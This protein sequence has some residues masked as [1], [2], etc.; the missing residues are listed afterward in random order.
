MARTALLNVMVGAALK[1]GR[2]LARDFGEVENLQVSVKG[3][4]DFV[5]AADRKSEKIIIDELRKARPTFGFLTEETGEIRGD[6]DRTHRWIVDP[7]DG[8]TNFL[9]G[10]PIFSISI[11]LERNGE[12]VAGVVYNPIMNELF[13]AEKGTGAFFNDRRIRV[14]GRTE[15]KDAVIATGIPHLGRPMQDEFI[16]ELDFL[17]RQVSGVRR[18]GSAALDLSWLA[19]GRFDG[20]WE[21]G[22]SPW[23]V[24]AGIVI[25]REAGGIVT[26]GDGNPQALTGRSIVAANSRLHPLL[27]A[28]LSGRD[29]G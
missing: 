8:T 28:A 4:G 7:L 18:C 15:L 12:I 3:P 5:S 13:T 24:A 6:D 21:H 23:D 27:R 14:A 19:A 20:F 9:H 10:V 1:A 16:K 22:L 17:M 11:G 29:R 26:D 25:L 2:T